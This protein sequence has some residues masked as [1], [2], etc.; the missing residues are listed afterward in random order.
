MTSAATAVRGCRFCRAPEG[1]L[2]N[3]G[4]ELSPGGRDYVQPEELWDHPAATAATAVTRMLD[5]GLVATAAP[6]EPLR[7]LELAVIWAEQALTEVDDALLA[8][9]DGGATHRE[10]APV[11]GLSPEGVRYRLRLLRSLRKDGRSA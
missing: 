3:V 5:G 4:C 1:T 8:A 11:L 7:R 10:L 9:A 6:P 2:H